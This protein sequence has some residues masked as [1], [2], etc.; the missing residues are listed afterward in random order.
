MS[1]DFDFYTDTFSSV[2]TSIGC[3][4]QAAVNHSKMIATKLYRTVPLCPVLLILRQLSI[5]STL[6]KGFDMPKALN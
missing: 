2:F 4:S 1:V 6:E 3:G 5:L